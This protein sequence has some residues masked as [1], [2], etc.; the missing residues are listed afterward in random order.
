M[1]VMDSQGTPTDAEPLTRSLSVHGQQRRAPTRRL[2]DFLARVEDG[3]QD[4]Y[5][6]GGA[7]ARLEARVADLLGKEAAVFMPTG[8][9]ASQVALRLHADARTCRPGGFRPR[10]HVEVPARRGYA[11]VD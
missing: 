5:G 6:R 1:G 9:M 7:V 11:S 8:A 4:T 3:D 10:A 2:Q